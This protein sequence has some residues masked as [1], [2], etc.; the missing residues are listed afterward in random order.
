LRDVGVRI[1]IHPVSLLRLAMGTADRA[2]DDL[3]ATG[4][5]VGQVPGMQTRAEL[6][7]LV[8]Y[9]GYGEFDSGIYDFSLEG[10]RSR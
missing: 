6:Y 9:A 1:V 3:L 4:S 8:D 2:L 10:N 5:L 7:D